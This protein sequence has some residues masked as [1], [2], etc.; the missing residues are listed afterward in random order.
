MEASTAVVTPTGFQPVAK[1]S[2]V[3]AGDAE[4]LPD[5]TKLAAN[6]PSP[7]YKI[8]ALRGWFRLVQQQDAPADDRLASLNAAMALVER[9]DERKLALAALGS[10]P[11]VAALAVVTPYLDDPALKEE[12]GAAAVAIGEGMKKPLP[13]EIIAAVEKVAKL[14]TSDATAKRAKALLG[15]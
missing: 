7:T 5:L 1:A 3:A 4:A 9:N 13:P 6:A 12:A 2:V 15:K 8:L 14:T 10:V 11:T